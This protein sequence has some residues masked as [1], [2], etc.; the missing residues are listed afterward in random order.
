VYGAEDN[1]VV[2]VVIVVLL[3]RPHAAGR[4]PASYM[5]SSS[6]ACRVR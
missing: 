4:L 3:D 2:V 6:E 5:P 1:D